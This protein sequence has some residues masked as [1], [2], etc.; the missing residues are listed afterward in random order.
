[1]GSGTRTSLDSLLLVFLS[2]QDGAF[3]QQLGAVEFH[4]QARYQFL[5]VSAKHP[6]PLVGAQCTG[7]AWKPC[8]THDCIIPFLVFPMAL[9]R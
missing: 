9:C 5:R 3:Q 1:M 2:R 7:L 4:V 6:G 8:V